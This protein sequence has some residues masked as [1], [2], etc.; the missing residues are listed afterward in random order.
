MHTEPE[1]P[2]TYA[3]EWNPWTR[4]VATVAGLL[5]LV[6]IGFLVFRYAL[7][8]TAFALVLAYLLY[9]PIRLLARR[10]RLRYGLSVGLVFVVYLA[11]LIALLVVAVPPLVEGLLDLS[12]QIGDGI[13][14]SGNALLNYAPITLSVPDHVHVQY[15]DPVLHLQ[16]MTYYL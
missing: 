14:R 5:A 9:F 8:Y 10:T 6:V 12:G 7:V 2:S 1:H 13:E 15:I 11:L 4:R 3:F 16:R